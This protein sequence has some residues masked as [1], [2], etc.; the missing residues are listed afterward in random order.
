MGAYDGLATYAS[1]FIHPLI[2]Y[3]RF[4]SLHPFLYPVLHVQNGIES[5]LH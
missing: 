4:L 5:Q 2:D 3:K 1:F